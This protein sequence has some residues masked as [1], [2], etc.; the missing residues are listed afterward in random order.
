M[1]WEGVEMRK[2]VGKSNSD[3]I[4]CTLTFIESDR[5]KREPSVNRNEEEDLRVK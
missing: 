5:E 3:G 2:R 1:R 4:I